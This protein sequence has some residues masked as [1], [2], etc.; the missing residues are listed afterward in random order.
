MSPRL[1][2]GI[3]TTLLLA[4]CTGEEPPAPPTRPERPPVE[5]P[6]DRDGDA[7]TAALRRIDMCKVLD[8]GATTAGIEGHTVRASSP[9]ACEIRFAEGN[10]FPTALRVDNGFFSDRVTLPSTVIGGAK[11]YVYD[12]EP[13]DITFPV[14]FTTSIV[15]FAIGRTCAETEPLAGGV[16][17]A[18]ADFDQVSTEPRWTACEV[19]H[20]AAGETSDDVGIDGCHDPERERRLTFDFPESFPYPRDQQEKVGDRTVWVS[21]GTE[22]KEST[23]AVRWK[24]DHGPLVVTVGTRTC[25]EARAMVAPVDRVLRQPPPEAEP[26][27]PLLYGP[28][29]P[30]GPFAGACAYTD[31]VTSPDLCAPHLRV[32]VPGSGQDLV[33]AASTDADVACS[34]A[35]GPV[36]E[37]FG[38]QMRA[39]V[40]NLGTT[41]TCYFVTPQRQLQI[42]FSVARSTLADVNEKNDPTTRLAGHP[43]L[44]TE[45]V[46][47]DFCGL[48]VAASTDAGRRG[49]L[50][51]AIRA[52]PV[53]DAALIDAPE[54][55][56]RVLTDILRRYFDE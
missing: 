6:A 29:E 46:A 17:S 16:V 56:E 11:A 23:C 22:L 18:L 36:T 40:V 47:D 27:R 55:G 21:T 9:S 34:M 7:L 1:I 43:G 54:R 30:D 41:S 28:D 49:L 51:L 4:G 13:C 2:V 25:D 31:A 35:L 32:P 33:D 42:N 14:S 53:R 37:H 12:D 15:I 24:P 26:Q 45:C 5:L 44:V 8:R 48:T 10:R 19:L 52:G 50:N 3:V 39:V 38:D 20:A